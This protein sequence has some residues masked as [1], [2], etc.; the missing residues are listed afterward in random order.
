MLLCSQGLSQ[1]KREHLSADNRA[2]SYWKHGSW[3]SQEKN[4]NGN[5]E[6]QELGNCGCRM[7]LSL[8]SLEHEKPHFDTE[9]S[10]ILFL[11][12]VLPEMFP[13]AYALLCSMRKWETVDSLRT[14]GFFFLICWWRSSFSDLYVQISR[15]SNCWTSFCHGTCPLYNKWSLE[16]LRYSFNLLVH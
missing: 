2:S 4:K 3:V 13:Y 9:W 8:S 15:N 6:M 12:R 11:Q 1:N 14:W 7:E 16:S 10:F 5:L